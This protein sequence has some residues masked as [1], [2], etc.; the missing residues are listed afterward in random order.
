M[1]ATNDGALDGQR[2]L[3]SFY[4]SWSFVTINFQ[5]QYHWDKQQQLDPMT[6][7]TFH[8]GV[9]KVYSTKAKRIY[10]SIK[11]KQSQNKPQ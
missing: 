6:L 10:T 9:T 4:I 5:V 7:L 8:T 11:P 3:T 2:H 1:Y